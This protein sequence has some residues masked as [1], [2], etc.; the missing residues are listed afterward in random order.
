M[1]HKYSISNKKYTIFNFNISF[2]IRSS[3][4]LL[5]FFSFFITDFASSMDISLFRSAQVSSSSNG[6]TLASLAGWSDTLVTEESEPL[7]CW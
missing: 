3:D 5:P 4:V 1:T 7:V 2:D 6:S